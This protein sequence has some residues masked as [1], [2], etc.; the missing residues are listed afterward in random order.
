VGCQERLHPQLAKVHFSVL[1]FL[2]KMCHPCR[3][4][5]EVCSVAATS[6][7]EVIFIIAL[8]WAFL[9]RED[10]WHQLQ[11]GRTAQVTQGNG[12]FAGNL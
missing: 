8:E 1:A 11:T 9:D 7:Q 4:W 2:Q 10:E 5:K 6:K 3:C 12:S